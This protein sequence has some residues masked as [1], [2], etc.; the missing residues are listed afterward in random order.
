MA[1]D[2]LELALEDL[3]AA[4]RWSVIDGQLAAYHAQLAIQRV[5]EAVEAL[6]ETKGGGGDG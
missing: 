6:R 4:R 1:R 5:T 3:A 2:R